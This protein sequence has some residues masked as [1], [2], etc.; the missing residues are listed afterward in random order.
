MTLALILIGGL[1]L[2]G[3][4]YKAGES[5]TRH[6][7]RSRLAR[8]GRGV[9][10]RLGNALTL[11]NGTCASRTCAARAEGRAEVYTWLASGIRSERD[12]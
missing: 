4:G 11:A 7:Y 3:S 8:L 12:S 5:N 6:E 9:E 2:F 1:I 10:L